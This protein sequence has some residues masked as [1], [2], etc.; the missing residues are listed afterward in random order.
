MGHAQTDPINVLRLPV[1]VI[2]LVHR[3]GNWCAVRRERD[4]ESF[5]IDV[6]PNATKRR[7]FWWVHAQMNAELIQTVRAIWFVIRTDVDPE[8]VGVRPPSPVMRSVARMEKPIRAAV[9]WIVMAPSSPMPAR[10]F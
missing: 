1:Y 4:V 2:R 10:V 7:I 9:S 5:P 3:T 8:G 6:T